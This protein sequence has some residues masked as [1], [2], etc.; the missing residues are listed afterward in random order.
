M[1][2]MRFFLARASGLFHF[3]P[4]DMPNPPA[5]AIA[6]TRINIPRKIIAFTAVTV[7]CEVNSSE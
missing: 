6:G 4:T 1:I 3:A 5:N 2:G 7:S